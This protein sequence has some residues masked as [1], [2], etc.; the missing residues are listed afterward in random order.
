MTQ[1]LSHLTG[2]SHFKNVSKD[3]RFPDQNFLTSKYVDR[4]RSDGDDRHE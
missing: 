3:Y 2:D 4:A 1:Q